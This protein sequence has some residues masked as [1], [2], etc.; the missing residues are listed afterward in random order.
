MLVLARHGKEL[1]RFQRSRTSLGGRRGPSPGCS[2]SRTVRW[3]PHRQRRHGKQHAA[4]RRGAESHLCEHRGAF[5]TPAL[6]LLIVDAQRRM[7]YRQRG[8]T[9]HGQAGRW[10]STVRIAYSDRLIPCASSAFTD[11]RP[12]INAIV[13]ECENP[14]GS[15]S[16]ALE[17]LKPSRV[18]QAYA[19]F[20][21]VHRPCCR[22]STLLSFSMAHRKNRITVPLVCAVASMC[23]R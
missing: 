8:S 11:T 14:A 5:A 19:D 6:L 15:P 3:H 20:G 4:I 7:P 18:K 10:G 16:S 12:A 2:W 13:G 23:M 9:R 22:H 17:N 21:V 1:R